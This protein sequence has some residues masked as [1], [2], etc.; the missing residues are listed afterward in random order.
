MI[1]ISDD[2]TIIWEMA[3]NH[4]L[5]FYTWLI[6]NNLLSDRHYENEDEV[7]YSVIESPS[8]G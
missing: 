4:I 6:L 7:N 2:D 3:S 1:F 5:H 8:M